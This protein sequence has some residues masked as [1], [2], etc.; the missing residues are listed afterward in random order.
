CA[1]FRSLADQEMKHADHGRLP[2]GLALAFLAAL[3]WSGIAPH[4]RLTWWLEVAPALAGFAILVFAY[5]RFPF[6]NLTY[7]LMLLHAFI[8]LVGGHYTYAEMP[9]FN[10]LR[11]HY[12]LSRN[13]YDRVGHF[14]QG[15]VPAIVAREVLLRL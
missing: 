1:S 2:L 4:D 9:A 11:D 5:R 13:Y 7:V 10:W 3:A 15:F 8:L 6:T 12:H 14:A